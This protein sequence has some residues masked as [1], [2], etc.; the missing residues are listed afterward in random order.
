MAPI[1]SHTKGRKVDVAEEKV[2]Y[3]TSRG[4]SLDGEP[5]VEI[6]DGDPSEKWTNPQLDA[7]ADS[8]GIDFS[9]VKNKGDRLAAIAAAAAPAGDTANAPAGD[10]G[11]APA[12]DDAGTD[13]TGSA[14]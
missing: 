12:G 5:V 14:D 2:E 1:L 9:G 3:F 7:Y 8:K 11:S 13:T 4:W 6:P 10:A